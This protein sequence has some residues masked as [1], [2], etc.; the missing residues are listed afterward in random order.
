MKYALITGGATGLGRG[1]ANAFADLGYNLILTSRNFANLAEAKKEIE[2][3]YS[4][5]VLIF[6]ADLTDKNIRKNLF[7]YTKHYNLEV[8]INNAG[9]GYS[10]SFYEGKESKEEAVIKLNVVAAQA[11]LKNYYQEFVAKK[12]GRIINVSSLAS[13][14]PSAYSATYG[15]SK[16]YLT[17]LSLAVR[18]EA[19]EHNVVIQT[20]APASIKTEF[21]KTAGTKKKAYKGNPNKIARKAIE[22]KRG[23]IIPGFKAK[24]IY[25]L[26]KI[27]PK[28]LLIKCSARRQKN[29]KED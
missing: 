27:L 6:V 12:N 1:F 28:P 10:E 19:K 3:K 17:H 24:T 5:K 8:V 20:L 2:L 14:I 29:K 21:Y 11:I 9:V 16:A 15:A 22:S 18:A 4:N 26:T 13:F 23:L 25:V 7:D